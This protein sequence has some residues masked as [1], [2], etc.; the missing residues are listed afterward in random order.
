VAALPVLPEGLSV[1]P[2]TPADVA[3]A[4]ALLAD[5]ETVDDTGEHWS[6]EDLTEWWV[7]DL[8]DLG[9][10][11]VAVRDPAG[12][13]VAW[14]TVLA[15]PTFRDAFRIDLEARVHPARRGQGLGRALLGWQVA[16]G[17]EIHLERHPGS[18]A[19]LAVSAPTTMPSLAALLRRAEFAEERWYSAMERRLDGL[20]VA[21]VADGV[22][23]VPFTW[24][25]D[26][27]VRRA[28][29][30][31]FTAHHGSAERDA[32]T[33]R[34]LFT[35]QRAFRPDLSALALEDGAVL[36]YALGYVYEADSHALGYDEVHLGQIGV[37]PSARGRGLASAVIAEVLGRAAQAGCSH[38]GLGV[39]TGNV[40]GALRLY[41]SLGFRTVRSQ[42][43]W[44]RPLPAAADG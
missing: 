44:S 36:G 39:D 19:V 33:W 10:D 17:R 7:N 15:L 5:A 8:V 13:L 29:N 43:T 32:T 40:T 6:A 11:G 37:L 2:L 4:A 27:E 3:D 30:A 24:D 22:R 21:P 41:E 23:L 34:H 38:A 25:R 35:G 26:E 14:A 18:P 16:R 42:V 9:R 12:A 31:S 28:H 20:P 1:A